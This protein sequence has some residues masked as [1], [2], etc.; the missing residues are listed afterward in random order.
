MLKQQL[1]YACVVHIWQLIYFVSQISS[2]SS[3]VITVWLA[4]D[5][6]QV[7]LAEQVQ[8]TMRSI[9]AAQSLVVCV[10]FC[11]PLSFGPY[12][13]IYLFWLPLW[14]LQ[15]LTGQSSKARRDNH[16]TCYDFNSNTECFSMILCNI[17]HHELSALCHINNNVYGF[18]IFCVL[19]LMGVSTP[20]INEVFIL[21]CPRC[22]SVDVVKRID[23]IS[24]RIKLYINYM[25][26][27]LAL[28]DVLVVGS[29]TYSQK[30]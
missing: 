20:L 1:T 23:S 26:T 9:R 25:C 6:R 8:L 24:R 14:R 10:V 29:L 17:Y 19:M 13:S 3:W 18:R 2:N 22:S 27:S 21:F 4:W 30:P 15:A 7:P 16:H 28:H 11:R 12:S 5:E